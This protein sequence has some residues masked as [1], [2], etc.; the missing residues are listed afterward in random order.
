MD[1]EP[2]IRNLTIQGF[3]S[4]ASERIELD[5]PTFLVGRNGAGKSN[6]VDAFA[7]L[8]EAMTRA[9]PNLISARGGITT[10]FHKAPGAG[11]PLDLGL[12]VELGSV[13]EEIKSGTYGFLTR[14]TSERHFHVVRERFS[15]GAVSFDR[16]GGLNL[17]GP[18]LD[19]LPQ[20]HTEP[21]SLLLP[22]LSG[23]EHYAPVIRALSAIRAYDINPG[24][25]REP[26]APDK[27]LTLLPDGSN[28]ASVLQEIRSSS[29]DDFQA[30]SDFLSVALPYSVEIRS[31][32]H[33]PSRLALEM[34][35][36]SRR[37]QITLE[38]VSASEGMLR[39][40]GLLLTIFQPTTP[41][42]LLIEEPEA[43]IHPDALG[44]VV[45][46]LQ[47]A[48][49]RSQVIVTTHSP[50]LLD[51]KWIGDRHLRVVHWEDGATWVSPIAVGARQSL[52]D[53]LMGAGELLR[54]RAL[55]APPLARTEQEPVLFERAK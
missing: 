9:L 55:D 27:G 38:A 51:A 36:T 23:V 19:H 28:A 50:E 12:E 53:H 22:I 49:Q 40:L 43:T 33:S 8:G 45:D 29:P 35:Q 46:L 20:P 3:R 31:T 32:L 54:A 13:S 11:Y 1:R 17:P 34:I 16:Q 30:I 39:L 2:A 41:S 44:I 21:D 4:I 7:L 10:V 47:L 52:Q 42:V 26:A 18:F 37:G 24:R 6:I 15:A 48:T 25:L 14:A 5:N